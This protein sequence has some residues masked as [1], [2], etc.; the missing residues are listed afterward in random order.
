M[1]EEPD[2]RVLVVLLE[3][4]CA[5]GEREGGGGER[6]VGAAAGGGRESARGA[7]PQSC[8]C[9]RRRPCASRRGGCP[10]RACACPW[11]PGYSGRPPRG[12]R[13]GGR[14]PAR[15][16]RAPSWRVA[17]ARIGPLG[18]SG[19]RGAMRGRDHG[20]EGRRRGAATRVLA[21]I[22]VAKRSK[23]RMARGRG[24]SRASRLP[25]GRRGK[26]ARAAHSARWRRPSTDESDDL[27]R[28]RL[29]RAAQSRWAPG[30][31]PW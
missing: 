31:P 23:Q 1:V 2:G 20:R 24:R 29:F 25:P 10:R 17:R 26:A 22:E 16:G 3:G 12:G 13:A 7:H 30:Y 11:R 14:R 8:W 27:D 19:R 6:R 4:H 15:A 9:T 18:R 28:R 5:R 21:E